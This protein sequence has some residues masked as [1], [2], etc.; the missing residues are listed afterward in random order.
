MGRAAGRT[1]QAPFSQ[2]V[3]WSSQ[4]RKNA[5][6]GA[7][8]A[9]C[10][11]LPSRRSHRPCFSAYQPL[12][13]GAHF[14]KCCAPCRDPINLQNLLSSITDPIP[15]SLLVLEEQ[16][17]HVGSAVPISSHATRLRPHRHNVRGHRCSKRVQEPFHR[18]PAFVLGCS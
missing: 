1:M 12:W 7:S 17:H 5:Y 15:T 16:P 13:V 6:G 4:G 2:D 14:P 3:R 9:L 11:P 10:L 18:L 8:S